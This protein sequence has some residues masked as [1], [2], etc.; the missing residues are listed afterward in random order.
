MGRPTSAAGLLRK[1]S[2][3]IGRCRE[4]RHALSLLL[5]EPNEY[6]ADSDPGAVHA[7]R[8]VRSAL[9]QAC[10]SLDAGNV[11]VISL[12][13]ER[14]AVILSDCERSAAVT[15]AHNIADVTQ[16]LQ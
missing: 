3:A 4:R 8:Q 14:T 1:L 16:Q 12:D 2:A 11:S 9:L 10:Q 5:V 13:D 7:N 15:L 6:D